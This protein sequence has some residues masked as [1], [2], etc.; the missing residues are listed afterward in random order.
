MSFVDAAGA[1]TGIEAQHLY[2]YVRYGARSTAG[3]EATRQLL[4]W[5]PWLDHTVRG[6]IT[7]INYCNSGTSYCCRSL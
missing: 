4:A 5:Q 2:E 6:G 1:D 3:Q 7:V